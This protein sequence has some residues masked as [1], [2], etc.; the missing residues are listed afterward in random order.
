MTQ[1]EAYNRAGNLLKERYRAWYIAHS[2]MPIW[3]EAV[4]YQIHKYIKGCQDTILANMNWSF[5][6]ERYFG[7]DNDIVR[8][9][10]VVKVL[11]QM[12]ISAKPVATTV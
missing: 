5:K 7:K 6:S 10:R 1:Q 9:T 12:P 8:R 4:D 2:E 11:P 3:G